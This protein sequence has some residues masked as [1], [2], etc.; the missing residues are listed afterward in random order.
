MYK[1]NIEARSHNY[2]CRSK[3]KS[4]SVLSVCV[5]ILSYAARHGRLLYY[6]L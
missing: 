4:I 2:L 5:S 3:E 1:R 6:H